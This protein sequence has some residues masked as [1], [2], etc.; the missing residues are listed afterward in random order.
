MKKNQEFDVG[1]HSGKLRKTFLTMKLS[2]CFLIMGLTS[3]YGNAFSQLKVNLTVH[4]ATLQEVFEQLTETTD[5]RFVYSSDLLNKTQ[6]IT[7]DFQ[8]ES[9]ESVLA[10]CLEGT[11]LWYRIEGEDKVVIIS[12]KFQ[13]PYVPVKEITLTGKV[14][15]KDGQ[16]L[17]GVSVVLKGTTMGVATDVN[18]NFTLVIPDTEGARLVFSF[19]GM[20]TQEL[21]IV[22]GKPMHVVMIA[23]S[24]QMEEVIVT[25]Y[26]TRKVSEM[27]GAVQQF[28]GADIVQSVTGGNVMNALKGH[29]T[30]LH[31]TGSTGQPGQDGELLLRGIGTLFGVDG[32]LG[33]QS[34]ASPL[35]VIDGVITDYTSLSG[36]VAPTDIAD[37][38]VLKDA[39]STAIYGS[40]AATGV[41][42]VT[43]KKGV[44]DQM[45]VS[46]DMKL[47]INVPN[48]GKTEWMTSEELV[49]FGKM[50][51]RNW[52]DNNTTLQAAYPNRDAFIA[53]TLSSLYD[54]FD[55]TKTTD[56]R[57][58]VYRNGL[59]KD[60][61]MSIRGGGENM[62]YYF[63]YNY[64]DEEGTQVG[65]DLTRHLFKARMDFDVK[66]WLN[67]GVNLSGTFAKNISPNSNNG[68][69][70]MENKHPWLTPYNEDGTLKYNIE[71]WQNFVMDP[72]PAVNQLQD[73]KYNNVTDLSSNLFGSF[74]GTFKPFKW[75]S[76]TS[77][78]TLTLNTT[79]TNDYQDSRTYSGNSSINEYSNG[80]L[81]IDDSRSWSFLTSN[82]L[83][84]QHNF[85][86]HSLNGLIRQEWYER[87]SRS[88]S[89]SMY[90]QKI[91][92]ERN[93]GGFSMQGE[94][95]DDASIPTGNETET[96]SFS[97]FSEVNYNYAGKYMASAS[98]RTDGSTNFGRD[99][100]YGTFY[101][102]S[103]SWLATQE[104]FMQN[105]NV[106]SNL[107]LRASY[108]TSGKEA[109]IDY[110]NYTLYTT[111][112]TTFDY[113]RNHPI[114]QSTYGA[115]LNQLGNDQLSWETA[116]NLNIGVDLG[117]LEN[118]INLSVDW[119]RRNNTD[120][121]M[122][123]SL[124]AA[125]AVGV[126]YQNVGKMVNRGIELVL[127]THTMK[128]KDFN[129]FTTL[130]F[131]YN[132]NEL[133]NLADDRLSDAYGTVYYEGDNFDVLKKVKV[134]GIDPQTGLPQ[135]E[136]VEE[137]GSITIVN[138]L[139]DATLG[140]GE[141]SYVDIGLSRAPY[142]G[143]FT[144]TLTYKNWELYVHTTYNLK[145]KVY[146][147]IF[148]SFT[149]GRGWTT[150]NMRKLPSHWKIWEQ[151]GDQADLPMVNADP[152]NR[153][154]LS[155]ST[156]FAYMD[157][158]HLR[159]SNIRLSYH[160]PQRWLQ[161]VG[162]QSATLSFNCDN[163]YTFA[164]KNF[165]H[166][167]PENLSGWAA[168]RQFIFGLNVTF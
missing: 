52:W 125:M 126:Q 26:S 57:D 167:D 112:N 30:G 54:N 111:T 142:W 20:K 19:V 108:G 97:V 12:P 65:Y 151:P 114:Y 96:G 7:C 110:L 143:G 153:Q 127:N 40:R 24:E 121:I 88:S 49:E 104:E 22:A 59:T 79:N 101:S 11:N 35:I 95:G 66:E 2:L 158:S 89:V 4:N 130:T 92:G 72:D 55:L 5:Y 87:H 162:I 50:S 82:I 154:D 102:V 32:A 117:F 85:G 69:P 37:I 90:D 156:S 131:S 159:I 128:S 46:L 94:K 107:K 123:V 141:L 150:S 99:K 53:D 56:W 74:S 124:P 91:A 106:F 34:N 103:A 118:R 61:A 119:Y 77:T 116:K 14:V 68:D 60:I 152:A 115:E 132:D 36:V 120:L 133:T 1:K 28:R 161:E 71:Q 137:D 29:T 41:I 147:S 93:V 33:S 75:L 145:Y 100:R 31:I 16:P 62:Q 15:D 13:R 8:N 160:F 73:N 76:F 10:E 17:P 80:T 42:V 81:T 25:G 166:A 157:A 155:T 70:T 146:N 164:S 136:R 38:T 27:T 58:L 168:P 84:L 140:N 48:F 78:N 23:D 44:K 45:Q 83:R 67:F 129:W 144:N 139:V 9:I 149:S 163:V 122:Q 134:A 3:V 51:L 39:A 43:T 105:Q 21:P 135:Y 113:Y 47:G 86:N 64:Y 109:G 63:S 6:K 138:S 165:L 18:G 98:F 148:Q